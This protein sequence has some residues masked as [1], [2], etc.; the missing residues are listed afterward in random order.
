M[1]RE[2]DGKGLKGK[3]ALFMLDGEGRELW[4]EERQTSGW[5]TIAETLSGWHP[6]APDYILAYR[7]GGGVFP[8]L[9]DGEQRIVAQFGHEGYAVHGDLLGRGTEQVI[10]Y[11]DELAVLF[12]S[13][14]LEL[15]GAFA[16][17]F[18]SFDSPS[19]EA[20]FKAHGRLARCRNRNGFTIPPC[21]REEK[22]IGER[23]EALVPPYFHEYDAIARVAAGRVEP[24]LSAVAGRFVGANPPQ[25]PGVPCALAARVQAVGGLP[26]RYGFG[27]AMARFDAWTICIRVGHAVV[28][29]GRG[30]ALFRQL[31]QPGQSLCQRRACL[32]IKFK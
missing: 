10:I 5:L 1:V 29:A 13:E 16:A 28:R 24:V 32:S 31:L 26:L 18:E 30:D 20:L 8:A 25:A 15:S 11:D 17:G 7:R 12:A 19:G 4:K 6:G 14:P 21:T 27:P 9:Y 23:G 3:D 22:S 2:D